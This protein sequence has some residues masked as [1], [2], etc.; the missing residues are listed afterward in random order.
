MTTCI[1]IT[2]TENTQKS[3]TLIIPKIII[4]TY[5]YL[6]TN[7]KM[8]RTHIPKQIETNLDDWVNLNNNDYKDMTTKTINNFENHLLSIIALNAKK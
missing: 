6:E 1:L 4:N 5:C 8:S 7:F 2:T 3:K